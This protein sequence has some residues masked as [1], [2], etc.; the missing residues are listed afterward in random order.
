MNTRTTTRPP[1]TLDEHVAALRRAEA[2]EE[3][4]VTVLCCERSARKTPY[5][6]ASAVLP[7]R[8]P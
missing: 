1:A 8:R 7:R 4:M 5:T 2:L 3:I 6:W